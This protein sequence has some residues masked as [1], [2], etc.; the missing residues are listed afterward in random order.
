MTRKAAMSWPNVVGRLV[1]VWAAVL[2]DKNGGGGG[3][4]GG[5]ETEQQISR[6]KSVFSVGGRVTV[7]LSLEK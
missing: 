3:R 2:R 7:Q 4:G 1:R 5:R 6:F